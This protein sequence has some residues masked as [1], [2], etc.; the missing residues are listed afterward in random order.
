M[1]PLLG[2]GIVN[3]ALESCHNTG[4]GSCKMAYR[5][6]LLGNKQP[7]EQHL[8][9]RHYLRKHGKDAYYGQ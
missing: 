2:A 6:E 1:P 5:T 4:G 3:Q 9:D 7:V 8:L